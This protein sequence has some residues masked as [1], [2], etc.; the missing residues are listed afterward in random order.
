MVRETATVPFEKRLSTL[1][2]RVAALRGNGARTG[3]AAGEAPSIELDGIAAGL[4]DLA[5]AHRALHGELRRYR[6]VFRRAPH[7][8]LVTTPA[9][10]ITEANPASVSLLQGNR[11]HLVG[12]PVVRFVAPESRQGFLRGLVRAARG[13]DPGEWEVRMRRNGQAPFVALVTVAA[14]RDPSANLVA[15]HWTLQDITERKEAE[16][17]LAH[18][19]NHDDL[20]GLPNRSLFEEGLGLAL[21]RARRNGRGVAVLSLDLDRFKFVNDTLGHAAGDEVLRQTA[22]R[23]TGVARDTDLVARVGGDEFMVLLADL[24]PD[25]DPDDDAGAG[26][27]RRSPELVAARIR[28]A[29]RTPCTL[30]A[31]DVH[32]SLSIGIGLSFGD[33]GG[34]AA[35]VG[36]ADADMYRNKRGS[37]GGYLLIAGKGSTLAELG[38][39][40]T[41]WLNGRSQDTRDVWVRTTP[42]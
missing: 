35:L 12:K 29:T 5:S 39:G 24:D 11:N 7:G 6:E 18:R 27:V 4:E 14:I 10:L 36:E 42:R 32:I 34:K 8:Y 33:G 20:T 17:A 38:T 22:S 28:Q 23:L 30:G 26:E 41:A 37:R 25:P 15:L 21:A 40:L 31:L 9:G 1:R 2:R 19:A 3:S 13:G 16:E